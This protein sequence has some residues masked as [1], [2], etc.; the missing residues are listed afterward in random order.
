MKVCLI[1]PPDRHMIRTNV[2][3][4]VDEVTGKYPPLGLLYVAGAIERAGVH[5]VVLLDCVAEGLDEKAL[6]KRLQSIAPDAVGIGAITFTIL[7]TVGVARV[8]KGIDP[9]IP[10]FLGGPH[11]NLYPEE[12]LSVAAVDYLLLGEGENNINPFLE[13]LFGSGDMEGVPGSV[14]RK[15]DGSVGYG[16]ANALIEDLDSLPM[17]ARHLLDNRLYSS[18]LGKG[19]FLTTVMSSRGCP[20]R[21]IFCDRPHLGKKFRARSAASVVEEMRQ[22]VDRFGIREFFFYDDTFTINRE[23]VFEICRA[24]TD[25]GL[26]VLWDIRARVSTVDREVLE[27]LRGAGCIRIHLGIESG[28]EEV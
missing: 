27:A 26:K 8:V 21:C 13:A 5:E 6:E 16:P 18:V 3:S 4:V 12:T 24:V 28:N 25:S 15:E 17:P 14:F 10:V 2:P 7:D 1:Y 23:R 22:C 20:A 11:V 9:S 19:A